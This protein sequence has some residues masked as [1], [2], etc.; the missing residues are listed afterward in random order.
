MLP[1]MNPVSGPKVDLVDLL[2][3]AGNRG[4]LAVA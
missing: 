3:C 2:F 1:Y 4:Q